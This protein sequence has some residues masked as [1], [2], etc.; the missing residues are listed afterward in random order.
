M[1]SVIEQC[2]VVSPPRYASEVTF[3]LTCFDHTWLAFGCTQQILFYNHHFVQIIVPSLKHSFSLALKHY[4]IL[5]GNLVSPLINSS[6]YPE[7]RYKT[8]DFV[9][10]TFSETTATDFNYLIS[11]HPRYAKDFYPFIPQLA[12]PKNAPGV[13]LVSI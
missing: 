8:G 2:Q 11:N 6:G 13:Q 1:A 4:T 3:Q 7:L 5:S 12:E 10:V 9:F